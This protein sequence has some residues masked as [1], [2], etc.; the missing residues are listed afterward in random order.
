MD[1]PLRDVCLGQAETN[2]A[3]LRSI[4]FNSDALPPIPGGI[5]PAREARGQSN[6]CIGIQNCGRL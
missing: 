3:G 5:W 1:M 2:S 6:Q 4:G